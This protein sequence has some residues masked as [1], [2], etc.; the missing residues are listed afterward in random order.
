MIELVFKWECATTVL[1]RYSSVLPCNVK[2]QNRNLSQNLPS[3][4]QKLDLLLPSG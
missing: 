2:S 1:S 3:V 4:W